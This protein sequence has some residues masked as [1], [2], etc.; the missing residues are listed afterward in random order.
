MPASRVQ[1]IQDTV[2]GMME[3]RGMETLV[4]E[5]LRTR[6]VQRLRR[7]RQ[8]GLVHLVFPGG[9]HSRLVHSVGAAYLA[10]L[11]GRQLRYGSQDSVGPFLLPDETAVRDFALAALFHDL[12]HGPLSH[13]WE[14][15]VI[16]E[17]Y[18]VTRWKQTLGLAGDE[19]LADRR[20]K[21][22][23]LV[24]QALLAATD[25]ELHKTL[26]SFERGTAT[27]VRSFL[28]GQYHVPYLPRLLD[29][30]VD[31]DRAD[32]LRRDSRLCGVTYGEY[33]LPRLISTCT[34]GETDDRRLVVGFEQGKAVRV[35]EQFLIARRAM[36][37]A[38]Y[39][40]KT[41]RS[42][43]GMVALFLRRLKEVVRAG[44]LKGV[45]DRLIQPLMKMVSGQEVEAPDLLSADDFALQVL[46]DAVA[47]EGAD[48]TVVDLAGRILSRNLFKAV[49]CRPE[50]LADF[51]QSPDA[52]PKIDAALRDKGFRD[53]EFY[54]IVD[55]VTFDMLNDR[56]DERAHF[57]D[58]DGRA[59]E[60]RDHEVIQAIR[61][62]RQEFVRL[63][64]PE[65][66]VGAIGQ[67]LK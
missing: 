46:I 8:L 67:L 15:E 24:G 64:V 54:R 47:H 39:R 50:K 44:R 38:V 10:V 48:A 33:D 34:L 26:E 27:R 19:L 7:V 3:F 49:P 18:D 66:A 58:P 59:T 30:D 57:V 42:A 35:V 63:F 65:E 11:F 2:H 14:R 61:G 43:E 12:G 20:V 1:L 21:W 41:V 5:V 36:Y 4:V 55:K 31:V 40:H 37:E 9:E 13:A 22:H 62:H 56:R 6:E 32:F 28:L 52:Y 16:G 25:G 23:V 17:G 51:L 29:S 60:V 53:P 45:G